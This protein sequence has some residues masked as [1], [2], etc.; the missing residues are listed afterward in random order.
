VLGGSDDNNRHHERIWSVAVKKLFVVLTVATTIGAPTVALS[1]EADYGARNPSVAA[2]SARA[3]SRAISRHSV[4]SYAMS[5]RRP[6]YGGYSS[7]DN[8]GG[9]SPGYNEMLLTW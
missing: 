3:H 5:P 6:I 8:T 9:G 4:K 7:Y 1:F 2:A